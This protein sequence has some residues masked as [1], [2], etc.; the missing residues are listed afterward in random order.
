MVEIQPDKTNIYIIDT[1]VFVNCP[2]IIS[3]IDK[4]YQVSLSAKVVDE[5]D[6]LKVTL[7]SYGK[8][9]VQDAIRNINLCYETRNLVMEMADVS[10]LPADFSPKSPDNQIL[11]VALKLK[12]DQTNPIMLTSDNGLQ[13]KAKGLGLTT[14]SLKNFLKRPK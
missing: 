8:K 7:N 11:S 3:K 12:N 9:N 10:L 4:Q 5:L 14:I 1:N 2:N 13:L 6:K